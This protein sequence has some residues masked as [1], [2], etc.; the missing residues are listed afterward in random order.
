MTEA[1]SVL[2]YALKMYGDTMVVYVLDP[3]NRD[4][5]DNMCFW[6]NQAFMCAKD[7]AKEQQQ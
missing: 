5:Y 1:Q 3:T 7:V 4:S 6:Q 2:A